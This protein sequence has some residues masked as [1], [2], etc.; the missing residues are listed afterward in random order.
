M[1]N[2]IQNLLNGNLSDARGQAKRY[3]Y[4]KINLY[5]LELGWSSIRA[6]AA[7]HYLKTGHG[8]QAYCDAN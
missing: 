2:M 7:A 5:L 8:F 3:S 1:Q 6:S 4:D